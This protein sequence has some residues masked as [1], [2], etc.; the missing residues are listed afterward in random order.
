MG[1]PRVPEAATPPTKSPGGKASLD[2]RRCQDTA[3][4]HISQRGLAG[5]NLGCSDCVD[6]PT[7]NRD[8]DPVKSERPSSEV[9]P[10]RS[11]VMLGALPFEYSRRDVLEM[12]EGGGFAG[13]FDFVYVPMDFKKGCHCGYALVNMVSRGGAELLLEHF[14]GFQRWT[15]R[16][17]R[18]C[19][20]AWSEPLQG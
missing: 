20:P 18:C 13:A 4:R 7:A 12:L 16:S 10:A 1:S 2:T 9:P 11:T 6:G 15:L 8:A 3:G 19:A 5:R 14:R 17:E